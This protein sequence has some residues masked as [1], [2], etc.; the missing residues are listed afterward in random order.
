M[1]WRLQGAKDIR[2]WS[3]YWR[4]QV[5]HSSIFLGQN[6]IFIC[7]GLPN[8]SKYEEMKKRMRQ[9][10]EKSKVTEFNSDEIAGHQFE[11]V[12]SVLQVFSQGG[13][14]ICNVNAV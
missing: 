4:Q 11:D 14:L 7:L 1:H 13:P 9:K 2:R 10:K 3:G 5:S 8:L 12:D 6:L